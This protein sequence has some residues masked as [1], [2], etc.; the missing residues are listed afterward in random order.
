MKRDFLL[1][2][3]GLAIGYAIPG[4]WIVSPLFML[5]TGLVSGALLALLLAR[6]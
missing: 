4:E 1:V 6:L 3:V 5:V 2:P